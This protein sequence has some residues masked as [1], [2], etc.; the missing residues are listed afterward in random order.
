MKKEIKRSCSPQ[1]KNNTMPH[2]QSRNVLI[3]KTSCCFNNMHCFQEYRDTNFRAYESCAYDLCLIRHY[4]PYNWRSLRF[5]VILRSVFRLYGQKQ[6]KNQITHLWRAMSNQQQLYD[7]QQPLEQQTDLQQ[8]LALIP[9]WRDLLLTDDIQHRMQGVVSFRK[10]LSKYRG[11]EPIE[12]VVKANIIP[13]LIQFLSNSNHP[14]LQFEA[15]W[16]LTNI[17]SGKREHTMEVIKYGAAQKLINLLN[18]DHMKVKEQALW[19]LGNIAADS[20]SHLLQLN[21]VPNLLSVVAVCSFTPSTSSLLSVTATNEKN[22]KILSLAAW[23]L[24]NLCRHQTDVTLVKDII[25]VLAD[26][27]MDP[28]TEIYIEACFAFS[29][30]MDS[31]PSDQIQLV[32]ES[33]S[34]EVEISRFFNIVKR[35]TD[36][37]KNQQ[38]SILR[39]ILRCLCKVVKNGSEECRMT[40][41]RAGFLENL[42]ELIASGNTNVKHEACWAVCNILSGALPQIQYIV[43][44]DLLSDILLLLYINPNGCERKLI[45]CAIS[46]ASSIATDYHIDYLVEQGCIES[47]CSLINSDDV[48]I[49]RVAME[50]LLNIMRS[51]DRRPERKNPFKIYLKEHLSDIEQVQLTDNEA[52]RMKDLLIQ[53]CTTQKSIPSII[54][55]VSAETAPNSPKETSPSI[56]ELINDNYIEI[57]PD[58]IYTEMTSSKKSR[59]EDQEMIMTLRDMLTASQEVSSLITELLT[60]KVDNSLKGD[61][62]SSYIPPVPA[63]MREYQL[64]LEELQNC[65]QILQ[66]EIEHHNKSTSNA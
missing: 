1:V 34:N 38:G 39:A 7:Q 16:V 43:E 35:M 8:R 63:I 45:A 28:H 48:Q 18:C 9:A 21:I 31:I 33:T 61:N 5:V 25:P 49:V 29:S 52:N 30:L 12:Y 42:K 62:D 47:L 57:V 59:D 2:K 14:D 17:T 4:N 65:S 15:S 22:R 6:Q 13:L 46:N 51:G 54:V 24:K 41:I 37:M 64:K 3:V 10:L 58:E 11:V 27:I 32:L 56:S 36:L 50:G 60:C 23:T 19:A 55:P 53:Q 66:R 40:A 26:F 20:P 44:A